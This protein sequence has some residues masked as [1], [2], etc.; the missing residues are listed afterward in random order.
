MFLIKL[1][2]KWTQG[3]IARLY[4]FNGDTLLIKNE[5]EIIEVNISTL[6]RIIVK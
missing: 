3:S 4:Y 1:H 2:S 6:S 5:T